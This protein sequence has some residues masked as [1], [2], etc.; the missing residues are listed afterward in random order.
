MV[1]VM[2]YRGVSNL[3]SFLSTQEYKFRGMI[4]SI[5]DIIDALS[6]VCYVYPNFNDVISVEKKLMVHQNIISV[7][8]AFMLSNWNDVKPY[9]LPTKAI[10]HGWRVEEFF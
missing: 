2:A 5:E 9:Q 6:M 1:I 3:L 7:F 10:Y 8:S 4:N